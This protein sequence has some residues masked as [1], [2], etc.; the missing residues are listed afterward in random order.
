MAMCCLEGKPI[1]TSENQIGYMLQQDYLFPWKTIEENILLGLRLSK[2]LNEKSKS[3]ALS[4]LN[5]IGLDWHRKAIA[6]TIIR[7]N[8]TACCPH[9]NTGN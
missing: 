3:A 2:Q 7:W 5:Q 9:S 6:K 1:V 4:L 8:E